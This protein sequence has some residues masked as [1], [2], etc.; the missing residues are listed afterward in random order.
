MRRQTQIIWW[1][2]K[3]LVSGHVYSDCTCK[4]L[5]VMGILDAVIQCLLHISYMQKSNIVDFWHLRPLS[6]TWKL[7]IFNFRHLVLMSYTWKS[8]VFDFWHVLPMSYM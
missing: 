6:Y 3:E 2:V 7:D 4:A 8:D 1:K 5:T